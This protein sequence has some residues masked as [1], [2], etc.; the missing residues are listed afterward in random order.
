MAIEILGS[1]LKLAIHGLVE[2]LHDRGTRR[3]CA[4]EVRLHIV[5]EYSK[6]LRPVAKFG[7]TRRA[8]PRLLQHDPGVAEVRLHAVGRV[9]ITVVLN[10]TEGLVEPCHRLV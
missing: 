7:W 3:F 10:K 5:N 4:T 9:A 6:A 2:I 1:I 8:F